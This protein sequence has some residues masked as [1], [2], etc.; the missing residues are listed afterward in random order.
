MAEVSTLNMILNDMVTGREKQDFD[1]IEL[2]RDQKV[3]ELQISG[4]TIVTTC[5]HCISNHNLIPG[6][7]THKVYLEGELPC[8]LCKKPSNLAIPIFPVQI[9]KTFW[10]D[11][12]KPAE[13]KIDDILADIH[14]IVTTEN[15]EESTIFWTGEKLDESTI[16]TL[17][18]ELEAADLMVSKVMVNNTLFRDMKENASKIKISESDS[19]EWLLMN[20]FIEVLLYS[21]LYGLANSTANFSL[22]YH[23]ISMALK[24]MIVREYSDKLTTD[25][26][27]R[28]LD[29]LSVIGHSLALTRDFESDVFMNADLEIS[30]CKS[31]V[32]AVYMA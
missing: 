28:I 21:N 11:N 32:N 20:S 1:Q 14:D 30:F 15:L 9:F 12:S 7:A 8:F 23:N 6:D 4:S 5:K 17:A 18:P 29:S 19:V 2:L 26:K 13:S 25:T 31:I 10:K 27:N 3:N 22:S 24:L 16:A